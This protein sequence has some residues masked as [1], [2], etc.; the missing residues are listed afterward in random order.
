MKK[1]YML[2]LV[3]A[4]FIVLVVIGASAP[5]E[6]EEPTLPSYEVVKQEDVSF[7]NTVRISVSVVASPDLS[8]EELLRVSKNVV[9]KITSEQDVN[10][11]GIFFSENEADVGNIAALASVDWAPFGDWSRANEVETGNYSNHEYNIVFS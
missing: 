5:S 9:D 3:V 1:M 6:I 10:A 7:G 11:I 8:D 2:G 4:I